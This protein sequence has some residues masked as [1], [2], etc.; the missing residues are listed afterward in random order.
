[1]RRLS[2]RTL[3][4]L[5]GLTLAALL[6]IALAGASVVYRY[7]SSRQQVLHTNQVETQI[8]RIRSSLYAAENGRFQYVFAG[9]A[10]GCSSIAPPQ[11]I[12][13]SKLRNCALLPRI[14]PLNNR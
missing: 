9:E 3:W 8:E 10:E 1:M 5:T 4:Y 11:A 13:R 7:S 14:I 6:I 2:E 12:F